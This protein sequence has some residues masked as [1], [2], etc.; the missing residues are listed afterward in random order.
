MRCYSSVVQFSFKATALDN[1]RSRAFPMYILLCEHDLSGGAATPHAGPSGGRSIR[2]EE[3][4]ACRETVPLVRIKNRR[5]T[6][7]GP[8]LANQGNFYVA[9]LEYYTSLGSL[10]WVSEPTK[11]YGHS[12]PEATRFC[13]RRCHILSLVRKGY[14]RAFDR[15]H[16]LAKSNHRVLMVLYA[17]CSKV[18]NQRTLINGLMGYN[19][20]V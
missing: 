6:R 10:P 18:S 3:L 13:G 7:R 17:V 12:W 15:T 9:T 20:H 14:L 16:K 5:A 4:S 8:Q 19:L 1:R 11:P 2:K